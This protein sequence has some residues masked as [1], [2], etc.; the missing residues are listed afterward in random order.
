MSLASILPHLSHGCSHS[1][2]VIRSTTLWSMILLIPQWTI[3]A[4]FG[5]PGTKAPEAV[6]TDITT[7]FVASSH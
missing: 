1:Q 2:Q 5:K 7:M 4:D 3:Y 6:V